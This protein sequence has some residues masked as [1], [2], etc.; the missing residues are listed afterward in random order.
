MFV[1]RVRGST[2]VLDGCIGRETVVA[3]ARSAAMH[4]PHTRTP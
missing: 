1:L 2:C 4:Q 3:V